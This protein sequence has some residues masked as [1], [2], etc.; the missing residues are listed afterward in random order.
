[1]HLPRFT[2]LDLDS[3]NTIRRL[4]SSWRDSPARPRINA[5]LAL[6]WH[7]SLEH[8]VR[9]RELPLLIRRPSLGRGR[10]ILHPEGR[11]LLITDD[12]PAEYFF[13][14]AAAG[15]EPSPDEW[16]RLLLNGSL[17]V[18]R[19]LTRAERACADHR[20]TLASIGSPD[21]A[22]LGYSICHVT[23]VGIDR[24]PLASLTEQ[25]LMAHSIFQL[26]PV[27]VYLVPRAYSH[28]AVL[29]EFIDE[30]DDARGFPICSGEA[31]AAGQGVR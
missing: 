2:G 9:D 26:S 25:E 15:E 27:N 21:F 1:M 16:R 31:V 4:A 29:P 30:M 6:S 28:L 18:G 8:W 10:Q 20:C 5:S 14:K 3:R 13:A 19:N 11:T 12:A 22:S 17:P 7:R 23:H 24:G